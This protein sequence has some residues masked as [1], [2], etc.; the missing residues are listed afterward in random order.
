MPARSRSKLIYRRSRAVR[1]YYLPVELFGI[2]MTAPLASPGTGSASWRHEAESCRPLPSG[3]PIAPSQDNRAIQ[4]PCEFL[5]WRSVL[6]GVPVTSVPVSRVPLFSS[7]SFRCTNEPADGGCTKERGRLMAPWAPQA[8]GT[9]RRWSPKGFNNPLNRPLRSRVRKE[10]VRVGAAAV[11]RRPCPP[12]APAG[13]PGRGPSPASHKA[14]SCES[15]H[16]S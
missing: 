1:G 5:G 12:A 14:L 9:R 2:R 6:S 3:P 8:H 7:A 16:F 13:P 10:G 4:V 15:L 11:A